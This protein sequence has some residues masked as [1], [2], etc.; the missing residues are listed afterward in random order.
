MAT[1]DKFILKQVAT[2]RAR[3]RSIWGEQY[4]HAEKWI[5]LLT[6]ELGEVAKAVND[7]DKDGYVKELIQLAALAIATIES[8]NKADIY[9]IDGV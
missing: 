4:H 2:E 6:E 3:Q 5:S 8:Y 7:R 1:K 9:G